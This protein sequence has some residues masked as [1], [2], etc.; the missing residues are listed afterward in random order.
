[1]KLTDSMIDDF[2]PSAKPYKVSDGEGLYVHVYPNGSKYWRMNYRIE[3]KKK[4]LS[5]GVYPRVTLADA[6]DRK[7]EARAMLA[8]RSDPAVA[9]HQAKLEAAQQKQFESL[10]I[11]P[12][13]FRLSIADNSLTIQTKNNRLT[14]SAEQTE[15]VRAFLIASPNEVMP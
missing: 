14:L 5:F 6:R 13:S 10:A 15:A 7:D 1:M 4:T 8:S 3:G 9:K 2:K 12:P 11:A